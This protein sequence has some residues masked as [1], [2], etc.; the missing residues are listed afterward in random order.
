MCV[1]DV[2]AALKTLDLDQSRHDA[3]LTFSHSFPR[4][5]SKPAARRLNLRPDDDNEPPPPVA[6]ARM[7]P[8]R[9][10]LIGGNGGSRTGRGS[11]AN[12]TWGLPP[13]V[14]DQVPPDDASILK[15]PGPDVMI[16]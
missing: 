2:L 9:E 10:I 8:A 11:V 12:A 13:Q 6:S 16:S 14:A 3:A 1:D 15:S 7:P 4:R 5:R